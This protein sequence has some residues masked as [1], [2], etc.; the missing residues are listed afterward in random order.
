MY[1]SI[2][3]L[4]HTFKKPVQALTKQSMLMCELSDDED[5]SIEAPATASG[6]PWMD[7]FTRYYDAKDTVPDGMSNVQWWGVHILTDNH[8]EFSLSF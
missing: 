2:S 1:G 6:N 8:V 5:E 3:A 4:P 7:E